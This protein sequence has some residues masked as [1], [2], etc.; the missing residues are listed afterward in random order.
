MLN[1]GLDYRADRQTI[2]VSYPK[3][4]AGQLYFL[5]TEEEVT[6]HFGA[7]LQFWREHCQG[8]RVYWLLNYENFSVHPKAYSADAYL[9]Q[10]RAFL[11]ETSLSVLPFGGSIL[12]R[13]MARWLNSKLQGGLSLYDTREQ[14]EEAIKRLRGPNF[15]AP[16]RAVRDSAQHP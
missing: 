7:L 5:D 14:A 15:S 10:M 12:P 9:Q 13:S 16:S 4:A 11:T 6:E 1:M 2:Y 8:Q 3:Q